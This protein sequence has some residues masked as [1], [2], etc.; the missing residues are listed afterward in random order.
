VINQSST[1]GST[2]VANGALLVTNA[3]GGTPFTNNQLNVYGGTVQLNPYG[4]GA[5]LSLNLLNIYGGSTFR[6]DAQGGADTTFTVSG[7]LARLTQGALMLVPGSGA[8]FGNT[9]NSDA[10]FLAT[11]TLF[12]QTANALGYATLNNIT[13]SGAYNSGSGVFAPYV[14]RT[15]SATDA[16][17]D[18]VVYDPVLGFVTA[19]PVSLLANTFSGVT[20]AS[21]FS[22]TSDAAAPAGITDLFALKTTSNITADAAGSIL[23]IRS[24]SA[25]DVGGVL[26]NG[27][28]RAAP[29]ISAD[30]V[31][32]N[33]VVANSVIPNEGIVY[34]SG[35]YTSGTATLSGAVTANT[36]TKFGNGILLLS[37]TNKIE[38]T[39]AVQQG[40]LQQPAVSLQTTHFGV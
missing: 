6:L 20:T 16:T 25:S 28:G 39:L 34:V 21:V 40:V 3:T 1:N 15:K 5:A 17:A 33:S 31:F 2:A 10:R 9:N 32:A 18:F 30:L 12:G 37:G 8:D 7:T 4:A 19:A 24:V 26:L 14:V 27:V 23:R 35:G 29:V 38:S 36:F 22:G 13:E 11:G